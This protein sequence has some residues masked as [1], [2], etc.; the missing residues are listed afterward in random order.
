ML[1]TPEVTTI[2]VIGSELL[3]AMSSAVPIQMAAMT[4]AA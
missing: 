4:P 2:S 1:A 3:A